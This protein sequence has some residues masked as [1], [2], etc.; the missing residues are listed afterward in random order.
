MLNNYPLIL[1]LLPELHT[2][3]RDPILAGHLAGQYA[4]MIKDA[5]LRHDGELMEGQAKL[6]EYERNPLNW[7]AVG[8]QTLVGAPLRVLRAFGLLSKERADRARDSLALRAVA[9]V[10]GI[11]TFLASIVTIITGW[12]A[13]VRFLGSP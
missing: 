2:A 12:D 9:A 1:N 5:L 10:V 11:V 6:A 4:R 8:V 3:A 7:F 13:T